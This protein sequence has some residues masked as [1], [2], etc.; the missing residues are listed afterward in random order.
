MLRENGW[1]LFVNPQNSSLVFRL[2]PTVPADAKII[3]ATEAMEK[4]GREQSEIDREIA[5]LIHET[6]PGYRGETLSQE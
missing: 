2:D 6:Y 4:E 5:H 3:A 1:V